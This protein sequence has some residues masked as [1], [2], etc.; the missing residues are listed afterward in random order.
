MRK[1]KSMGRS[2][3]AMLVGAGL[4]VLALAIVV[5]AGTSNPPPSPIAALYGDYILVGQPTTFMYYLNDEDTPGVGD[6]IDPNS[7]SHTFTGRTLTPLGGLSI[8]G[9]EATRVFEGK[10]PSDAP[11]GPGHE[12]CFVSLSPSDAGNPLDDPGDPFRAAAEGI[13]YW[14]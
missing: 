13:V 2:K 6:T 12:E 11:P 5:T 4:A 10:K 14:N 1:S 3:W 9:G 8:Q 7:F